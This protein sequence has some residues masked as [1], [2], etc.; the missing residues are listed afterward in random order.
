MIT[1]QKTKLRNAFENNVSTDIKLSKTQI[2]KMIQ[3]GVFIGPLL[4]KLAG[5]LMKV[6]A[7]LG[8]NISAPV[9]ITGVASSTDAKIQKKI[10]GPGTTTLT[11]SNEERNDIMKIVQAFEDSNVLLK[12]ITKAI[13]NETTEQ[14]GE[15]LGML[16]GILIASLLG[17]FQQLW[18]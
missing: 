8:K 5:S 9:E 7:P 4:S 17:K 2:F 13:E 14:K 16:V 6:V 1:R 10:H 15:F 12:G 11:I 3:Y 18:K